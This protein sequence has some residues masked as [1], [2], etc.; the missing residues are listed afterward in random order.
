MQSNC[1]LPSPATACRCVQRMNRIQ[2]KCAFVN[3]ISTLHFS[4]RRLENIS[5]V[6]LHQLETIERRLMNGRQ[7]F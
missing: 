3:Q 1:F 5:N 7:G 4:T 6:H 2:K